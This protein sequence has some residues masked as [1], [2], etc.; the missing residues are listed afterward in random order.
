MWRNGKRAR[1]QRGETGRDAPAEEG[2][3]RRPAWDGMGRDEQHTARGHSSGV[4]TGRNTRA[5][6]MQR[7]GGTGWVRPRGRGQG[8]G[9]DNTGTGVGERRDG[10]MELAQ[11]K[12]VGDGRGSRRE[13]GARREGARRVTHGEGTQPRSRTE[14]AVQWMGGGAE[15]ERR[16]ATEQD[17]HAET[18]CGER[19]VVQQARGKREAACAR[20]GTQWQVGTGWAL[21]GHGQGME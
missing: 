8:A 17:G 21:H 12:A 11:G 20:G 1:Q 7:R 16:R 18:E 5:E 4:G 6:S 2:H 14:R 19:R 15:C 9:A 3:G 13:E 10:C